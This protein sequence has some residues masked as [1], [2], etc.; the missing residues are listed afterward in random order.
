VLLV[1]DGVVC[2]C[3]AASAWTLL[4]LLLHHDRSD[5][6]VRSGCHQPHPRREVHLT[7]LLL[8]LLLVVVLLLLLQRLE[9]LL[10]LDRQLW[11]L[12]LLG[13]DRRV[14]LCQ[15]SGCCS[16][17]SSCCCCCWRCCRVCQPHAVCG[18][19]LRRI[20]CQQSLV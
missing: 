9:V 15:S 20:S 4:L 1:H 17:C 3:A 18:L 8:L 14:H 16:S 10:L 13:C 12:Q 19:Q 11:Q 5:E 7:V 2:C 6:L